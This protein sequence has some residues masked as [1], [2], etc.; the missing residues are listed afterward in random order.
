MCIHTKFVKYIL[1]EIWLQMKFGEI[2]W[3]E[4]NIDALKGGVG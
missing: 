1:K 4:V 2:F 3:F